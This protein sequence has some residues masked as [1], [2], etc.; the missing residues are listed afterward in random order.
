[1]TIK[2]VFIVAAAIFSLQLAASAAPEKK[3]DQERYDSLNAAFDETSNDFR[4]YNV[5]SGLI[6]SDIETVKEHKETKQTEL[7][8]RKL[9]LETSWKPLIFKVLGG[10]FGISAAA[11][12]AKTLPNMLWAA[13]IIDSNPYPFALR[14]IIEY[15]LYYGPAYITR[16]LFFGLYNLWKEGSISDMQY[17][18][19]TLS[20]HIGRTFLFAGITKYL[21]NKAASYANEIKKLED[22]IARDEKM[23][24]VLEKLKEP[25][26]IA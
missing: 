23:I 6:D 20:I 16:P 19:S 12:G 5:A 21:L 2:N 14:E 7:S 13:G 18:L 22:I 9:T 25:K 11:A 24:A 1:M 26:K 4:I 15:P 3:F 10:V 8:N 17:D